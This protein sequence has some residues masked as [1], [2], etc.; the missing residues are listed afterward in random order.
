MG[1]TC[2]IDGLSLLKLKSK[3]AIIIIVFAILFSFHAFGSWTHSSLKTLLRQILSRQ[4]HSPMWSLSYLRQQ[5]ISKNKL[6]FLHCV[7]HKIIFIFLFLR[8]KYR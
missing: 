3:V 2:L 4:A 5:G 6:V 8:I 1:P 7:I